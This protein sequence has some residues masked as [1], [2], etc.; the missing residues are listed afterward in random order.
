MPYTIYALHYQS[1]N[2]S[3]SDW[4]SVL[5]LCL[6]PLIAHIVPFSTENRF[7]PVSYWPSRAFRLSFF[8][9]ILGILGFSSL[10][11]TPANGNSNDLYY[12]VTAL[13]T[14]L[15]YLSWV[16]PTTV[17]FAVYFLRGHRTTIIPCIDSAWY[18]VYT[19]FIMAFATVLFVIAS[20]ETTKTVCGKFTS[21]A[22][23]YDTTD[24]CSSPF[25]AL[26]PLDP[27]GDPAKYGFGVAKTQNPLLHL[28]H[29]PPG[30]SDF[31]VRNFTGYCMGQFSDWDLS[32][33]A[34]TL[35]N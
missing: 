2:L 23:Q 35:E 13:L 30:P 27:K 1:G 31:W 17:I 5:T 3:F 9:V 24:V 14:I 25:H 15:F 33:F 12:T 10:W 8:L 28:N 21:M 19:M 34:T 20:I 11:I 32:Q 26:L 6:A 18:K 16:T 22:G 29:T 4:V 7:R